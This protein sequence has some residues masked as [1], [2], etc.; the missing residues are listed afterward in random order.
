MRARLLGRRLLASIA[1]VGM[2]ASAPQALAQSASGDSDC[3]ACG[4]VVSIRLLTAAERWEPLGSAVG[5]AA[6]SSADLSGPG[7]PAQPSTVSSFRIGRGGKNEGIVLLGSAG[8]AN[9]KKAPTSYE[10]R[11]W[12]VTVRLDDGQTR[13]VGMAYEPFVREGDRVR[14]AGN[15]VELLD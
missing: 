6:G 3:K 9:Y 8:G 5:S 11:R 15:N 13:A 4:R 7:G 14:I 1:A 12:E 10:H 2:I